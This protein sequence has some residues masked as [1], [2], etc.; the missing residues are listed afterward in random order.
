[1]EE[2]NFVEEPTSD[3]GNQKKI[4]IAVAAVLVVLCGVLGYMWLKTDNELDVNIE[5]SKAALAASAQDLLD[6]QEAYSG[7]SIQYD[8]INMQLDSSRMEVELLMQKLQDERKISNATIKQYQKEL[9]TLRTIMKGY[10]VQIDSLQKLNTKLTADAA[11]ARQEAAASRKKTEELSK[12]VESLSGQVS[13]GAVIKAY[14]L[15]AEAYNKSDKVTDRSSRTTYILTSLTLGENDLAEKGPVTVYIRVKD[16]EGFLLVNGSQKAFEYNGEV[17][18]CSASREV[19]Y[20]GAA[21]DLGI[22]LNDIPEFTKGVYTVEAYTAK[23]LLGTTEF[24]LR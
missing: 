2:F 5:E 13:A 16:P 23:A 3:N 10:I 19:D 17:M 1:M 12:T 4:L 8:T 20:Q 24:M 14:G 21:V 15:K 7:L 22:Y 6:L 18:N 9:G 11:A